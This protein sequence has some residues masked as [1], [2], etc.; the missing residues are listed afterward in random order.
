[1]QFMKHIKISIRLSLMILLLGLFS[2][3]IK[4]DDFEYDGIMYRT[5]RLKF[6]HKSI[7]G[8]EVIYKR[9]GYKG[10]IVIP[11]KVTYM[12]EKCIVIGIGKGAFSSNRKLQSITL[13]DSV[14]CID[15]KAFYRCVNLKTINFPNSIRFI[16]YCAFV[17]VKK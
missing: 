15:E 2:N 17:C 9:G 7:E 11:D 6:D 14:I 5:I 8:V 4:A 12:D 1:M 10:N 13:P 16:G 3:G